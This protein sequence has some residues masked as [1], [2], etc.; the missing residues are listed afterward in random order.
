[1]ERSRI[2]YRYGLSEEDYQSLLDEQ[3]GLCAVCRSAPKV[4]NG[5]ERKL[6]VDHSHRSGRNR[7]LSLIKPCTNFTTRHK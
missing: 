6:S 5:V 7:G 3:G 4:V 2:W 1:M